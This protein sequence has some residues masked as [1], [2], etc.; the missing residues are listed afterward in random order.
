[1]SRAAC[2]VLMMISKKRLFEGKVIRP[3][4]G[5]AVVLLVSQVQAGDWPQWGG[6]DERNFVSSETN[7]P[8][9]FKPDGCR[10]EDG[11]RIEIPGENLKWSASL[12]N[13]TY[14][15]PAI[16]KGKIFIG[17]NDAHIGS[18][19]RF[20]KTGGG[21]MLCLD[22]ATGKVQWQ[23]PIPRL[24]TKNPK[25]NYDDMNLGLCSSPAVD[26]DRVYIVSSRGE[27]LCLDIK[28]QADGNEPPFTDE[29]TYMNDTRVFPDKPGRFDPAATN[30]PPMPKPVEIRPAD[31]DI[32]WTYNFIDLLDVWPQDAV[33]C[34]I[35]VVGNNLF[36]CV[37][38][39]VDKSHKVIPSPNAPDIIVLDKKTGKFLAVMD[40]PL[41]KAIFH[42]DWSS[43]TLARVG[44]KTLVVWGGGDGFCYAFDTVFSPGKDEKPG[45]L[46][47][48]WKFD[49]NPPHNKF[50][51]GKPLPYNNKSQGPS[52]INATPVFCNNRIYV[53]VGQD[54]RHGPGPGCLSCIDATKTGD[55][56][57]SGRIWQC[58]DVDRSFSSAAVTNG[59]VF[60]ADY[61]GILRCLDADTGQTCWTHDLKGR[62]FASPLVADG[63]VY[64]GTESGMVTVA[65]ASK[66]KQILSEVKFNG[67]IYSTPVAANGVLYIASQKNLYAFC[68]PKQP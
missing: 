31:G 12:G 64:I 45:K 43:P 35:L 5:L 42:G 46:N 62:V 59:M 60:I 11:K 32:V 61:T 48:V 14:V 41:G 29:G 55:I 63:K 16:S 68:L 54:S 25:F 44:S 39:G 19:N 28:G 26:G 56:T 13:M 27:V 36:V 65:K 66:E 38:N 53:D 37:S 67:P 30:L 8:A 2:V 15:T 20:E 50:K 7:L 58:F 40:P 33:D 4:L 23:L 10:T 22:E 6:S 49:C 57:D 17:S 9:S 24:V 1:M 47:V 18:D 3:A 52:E 51:D 21:L 34:S